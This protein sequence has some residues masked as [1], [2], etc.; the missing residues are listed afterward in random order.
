MADDDVGPVLFAYDG[1]SQAKPAVREAA[2]QLGPGRRAIVMTAWEPPE[3]VPYG[4]PG[5]PDAEELEGRLEANAGKL[6]DEGAE[7]ARSVGFGA[8][9]LATNGSPVWRTIVDTAEEHDAG[10]IVMGSHG[11]TGIGLALMGSVASNVVR[12]AERPVLV[13]RG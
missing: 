4:G 3:L 6:A 12:H 5:Y 9:P 13:V 2:R 10:I 11:R 1:S 8:T 7:I